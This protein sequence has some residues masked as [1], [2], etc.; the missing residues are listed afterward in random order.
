MY[1]FLSFT[2]VRS[3]APGRKRQSPL[4]PR[5]AACQVPSLTFFFAFLHVPCPPT[6]S[7][8]VEPLRARCLLQD[9]EK[10]AGFEV[11]HSLLSQSLKEQFLF[12]SSSRPLLRGLISWRASRGSTSRD[13]FLIYVHLTVQCVDESRGDRTIPAANDRMM[14]IVR[15]DRTFSARLLAADKKTGFVSK[16]ICFT[17]CFVAFLT[18]NMSWNSR[19]SITRISREEVKCSSYRLT[20]Q[21]NYLFSKDTKDAD[22]S[23]A[24]VTLTCSDRTSSNSIYEGKVTVT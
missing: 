8:H 9:P 4:K 5:T 3:T 12:S 6:A 2:D 24:A 14:K 10:L 13:S 19:T 18:V 21:V 17:E 1:F 22:A 11:L 20:L 16:K 15:S 7:S 23:E